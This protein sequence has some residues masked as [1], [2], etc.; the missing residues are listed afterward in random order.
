M[1]NNPAN[2]IA[3]F[4]F[5]DNLV[6][7]IYLDGQPWWVATD[8]AK[9]LGYREAKDMVRRLDDDQKRLHMVSS[10]GGEQEAW[11][12]NESGLWM[13][14]LK[15]QR[16]EAKRFQKW[17]TGDLLPALRRDGYYAMPGA[18]RT[19]QLPTAA[20]IRAMR[21]MNA[22]TFA[23]AKAE[24]AAQRNLIYAQMQELAL[25]LEITLE[26][27]VAFSPESQLEQEAEATIDRAFELVKEGRVKDYHR[28]EEFIGVRRRDL[29]AAGIKLRPALRDAVLRHKRCKGYGSV[30]SEDDGFVHAFT[31]T[32][33]A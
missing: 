2:A 32:P 27:L 25:L 6:R 11:I 20:R 15:S 23:L 3:S 9:L 14:V 12:V 33:R 24:T 31:F 13:C 29:V 8:L 17:L 4:A 5:D 21:H 22:A 26:P 18:V 30:N 28:I 16:A 7:V 19:I 1:M 10:S